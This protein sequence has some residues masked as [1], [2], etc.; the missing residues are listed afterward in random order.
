M[1]NP[2]VAAVNHLIATMID[3]SSSCSHISVAY[4]AIINSKTS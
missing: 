1:R 3:S 2:G 4:D